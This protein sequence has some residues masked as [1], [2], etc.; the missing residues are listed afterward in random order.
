MGFGRGEKAGDL[1]QL[2]AGVAEDGGRLVTAAGGGGCVETETGL[3]LVWIVAALGLLEDMAGT[4]EGEA[5]GVDEALD[6]KH[7]LNVTAAIEPLAGA[8]LVG[9][10][11]GK[12]RFPEAQ[13]VGFEAADAGD[14]ANFEVETVGDRG[15]LE[16]GFPRELRS[17][18]LRKEMD[19][20]FTH[21]SIEPV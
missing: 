15:R 3:G 7:E 9:L 20:G 11:L 12:L 1:T 2:G 19:A 16:S 14:V 5:F 21:L 8:A 13:N 17:H 18:K 10:E 6:L 4:G